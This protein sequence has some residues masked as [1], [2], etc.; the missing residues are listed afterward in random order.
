MLPGPASQP[1]CI[2]SQALINPVQIDVTQIDLTESIQA[3]NFVEQL[4][5]DV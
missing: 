4:G 1:C 5:P 3:E 2:S